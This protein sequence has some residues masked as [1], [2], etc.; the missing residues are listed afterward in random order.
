MS[1][2]QHFLSTRVYLPF[3]WS[4]AFTRC[5]GQD[6]VHLH[7]LWQL[8]KNHHLP[9]HLNLRLSILCLHFQSLPTCRNSIS[10]LP[11]KLQL[12]FLWSKYTFSTTLIQV[13]PSP[14]IQG[15][16]LISSSIFFHLLF[17][18][19]PPNKPTIHSYSTPPHSSPGRC[20]WVQT[21]PSMQND[22]Q[23]QETG[24]KLPLGT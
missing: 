9:N 8:M 13:P 16:L 10:N 17:P 20:W 6:M 11:C 7:I 21:D 12:S 19:Q 4:T 15:L 18:S 2:H 5:C 24:E 23:W 1:N 3:L 14:A 22:V